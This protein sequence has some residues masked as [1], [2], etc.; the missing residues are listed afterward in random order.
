M[1]ARALAAD[2]QL[3]AELL[4]GSLIA[5]LR[6]WK[7]PDAVQFLHAPPPRLSVPAQRSLD[8]RTHPAWT[9]IKFDELVAQQLSLKAHRRARAARRAPVLTGTGDADRRASHAD[10]VQAHAARRSASGARS[11]TT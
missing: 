6:L 7:F 4:P 3:T 2:P 1:I 11:A 9:R 8:E 5:R 10:S